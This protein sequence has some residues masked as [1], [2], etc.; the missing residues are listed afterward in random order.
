MNTRILGQL[1]AIGMVL[2]TLARSAEAANEQT[3]LDMQ[4]VI[5]SD[6]RLSTERKTAFQ[7]IVS[8]VLTTQP[9]LDDDK[10][11]HASEH[12]KCYLNDR[13]PAIKRLSPEQFKVFES[14]FRWTLGNYA[15]APA[16]TDRQRQEMRDAILTLSA[17]IRS[18][19]NA[20][21]VDVPELVRAELARKTESKVATLLASGKIGNYFFLQ[22][23]Y[24]PKH[25]VRPETMRDELKCAIA[26]RRTKFPAEANA[27]TGERSANLR[28][29]V[30]REGLNLELETYAIIG[31]LSGARSFGSE[32]FAP[33]PQE[34]VEGYRALHA[35]S[36]ERAEPR[37]SPSATQ[38]AET[39]DAHASSSQPGTSALPKNST[40]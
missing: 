8:D 28:T 34:L 14:S 3:V 40:R 18:G 11:I 4:Q 22:Y 30:V 23:L 5:A 12:L 19:V 7:G 38:P 1:I 39:D 17:G 31:R 27:Q 6:S 20:V 32:Q 13:V 10:R 35:E 15:T 36:K 2:T 26:D 33:M 21:Y 16:I 37:R 9:A 25:E 24:P 29:F